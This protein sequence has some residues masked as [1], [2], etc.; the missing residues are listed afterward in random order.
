[1]E[2]ID[3]ETENPNIKYLKGDSVVFFD[4]SDNTILKGVIEGVVVQVSSDIS[5]IWYVILEEAK[6][7]PFLVEQDCIN[8]YAQALIVEFSSSNDLIALLNDLNALKLLV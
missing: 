8:D 3:V 4:S 7:T 6:V 2:I 5:S 1:M